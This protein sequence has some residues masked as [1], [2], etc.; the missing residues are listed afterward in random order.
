MNLILQNGKVIPQLV[1]VAGW[2]S[3]MRDDVFKQLLISDP[4]FLFDDDKEINEPLNADRLF[5][6]LVDSFQTGKLNKRFGRPQLRRLSFKGLEAK[7]KPLLDQKGQLPATLQLAL[8]I[9]DSCSLAGLQSSVA[10]LALDPGLSVQVRKLATYVIAN[11][12]NSSTKQKLK[13]LT[14]IT[15]FEDPEG[16]ILGYTLLSLWPAHI[17]ARKLFSCLREPFEGI[18]GGFAS[19]LSEI[20]D[21]LEDHHLSDA[22]DWVLRQYQM[23]DVPLNFKRLAEQILLIS[24]DH[25][26][27]PGV[28]S[29]VVSIAFSRYDRHESPIQTFYEKE[30]NRLLSSSEQVRHLLIRELIGRRPADDEQSGGYAFW[31]LQIKAATSDDVPFLGQLLDGTADARQGE[32]ILDLIKFLY[33]PL[34]DSHYAVYQRSADLQKVVML[35]TPINSDLATLLRKQHQQHKT[36]AKK[37]EGPPPNPQIKEALE[38]KLS[39]AENG[40]LSNWWNIPW[41]L[42]F[43]ERGHMQSAETE[44]ELTKLPGWLNADEATRKRIRVTG[45]AYFD[46]FQHNDQAE[47]TI[48]RPTLAAYKIAYM[49]FANGVALTSAMLAKFAQI[50]TK[51]PAGSTFRDSTDYIQLLSALL[52]HGADKIVEDLMQIVN[53]DNVPNRTLSVYK[54][55]DALW[56]PQLQKRVLGILRTSALTEEVFYRLLDVALKHRSADAIALSRQL[57]AAGKNSRGKNRRKSLVA[58]QLLAKNDALESWP[59]L[60]SQ[61]IIAGKYTTELIT[62]L[63]RDNWVNNTLAMKLPAKSLGQLFLLLFQQYPP[64]ATRRTGIVESIGSGQWISM[65]RDSCLAIL[66]NRGTQDAVQTLKWLQIK[67]PKETWLKN[68]TSES[69]ILFRRNLWVAFDAAELLDVIRDEYRTVIRDGEQL[70]SALVASFQRLD[71]RLQGPTPASIDLWNECYEHGYSPKGERRLSDYVKRHLISDL[72]QLGIVAAREPEI[73]SREELT[74]GQRGKPKDKNKRQGQLIDIYVEIPVLD[75]L[76]NQSTATLKAII[77]VKCCF[78]KGLHDD[79]EHQLVDRYL[80]MNKFK[81]GLYVAGCYH[82]NHLKPPQSTIHKH[83]IEELRE[84]L[85]DQANALSSSD[86]HLKSFVL[87]VALK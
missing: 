54:T 38:A 60:W 81:S 70:V 5:D 17:S 66:T 28:V 12:G 2:L 26:N 27:L 35:Q 16:E 74:R 87:D 29:K 34:R 15:P 45:T 23:P 83:S 4:E 48:D 22:L 9:V 33:D 14:R 49:Q 19:L 46:Q 64:V 37:R 86:F 77:E 41:I 21:T 43:D 11:L 75:K 82:C 57:V 51:C 78:N 72:W 73:R 59:T 76:L 18:V 65:W 56:C 47:N 40:D 71:Q 58:G 31:L 42:L 1:E 53:E 8:D 68:L 52:P 55:I 7:V 24:L 36:W 25:L 69:E 84:K 79:M 32:V 67:L 13:K 63:S 6:Q 80:K 50:A 39:E 30:Y 10:N 61:L 44:I 62:L 20:P 85:A 3:A